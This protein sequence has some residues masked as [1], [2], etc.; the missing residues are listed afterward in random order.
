MTR[1]VIIKS[2]HNVPC[3]DV[4]PCGNFLACT[5]IDSTLRISNI[6]TRTDLG[7]YSLEQWGWSTTWI[8]K[9]EI[10]VFQP[11]DQIAWLSTIFHSDLRSPN[12]QNVDPTLYAHYPVLEEAQNEAD[13]SMEVDEVKE[14]KPAVFLDGV[15]VPYIVNLEMMEE[16]DGDDDLDRDEEIDVQENGFFIERALD[17]EEEE[18]DEEEEEEDD[19]MQI[20]DGRT[21]VG[22]SDAKFKTIDVDLAPNANEENPFSFLHI[23]SE[24]VQTEGERSPSI[25]DY[26][27]LCASTEEIHL[28]NGKLHLLNRLTRPLPPRD[29]TPWSAVHFVN[30][31]MLLSW[32]PEWSMVLAA[33]QGRSSVSLLSVRFNTQSFQYEVIPELTI[34]PKKDL[35]Q[36]SIPLTGVAMHR[37]G[38]CVHSNAVCYKIHVQIGDIYTYHVTKPTHTNLCSA[39]TPANASSS[40]PRAESSINFN[41]T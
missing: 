7:K 21:A 41:T 35:P 25:D 4:S 14:N 20:D 6:S 31:Y 36:T 32:I 12:F 15:Q 22:G 33:N 10:E 30:R 29:A 38:D 40:A 17:A 16:E 1:E 13:S 27:I 3:I 19:Q 28:L 9:A 26:L 8:P 34:P 2:G 37:C 11:L 18:D 5:S 23:S 24:S 39:S